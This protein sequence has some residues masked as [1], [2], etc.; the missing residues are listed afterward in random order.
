MFDPS[1]YK[2]SCEL[3][4]PSL[5]VTKIVVMTNVYVLQVKEIWSCLLRTGILFYY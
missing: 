3:S 1:I 5:I 4:L 2:I